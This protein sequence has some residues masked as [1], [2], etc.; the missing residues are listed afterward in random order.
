MVPG[1]GEAGDPLAL[2]IFEQQAM[3]L[4]RL[5]SIAAMFTDPGTYFVGGRRASRP[6]P[7]SAEWFLG[8]IREHTTLRAEQAKLVDFVLVPDLDRAGRAGRRA[9]R[10]LGH[11]RP[12][13][14]LLGGR[15]ASYRPAPGTIPEA[16]ASTGSATSTAG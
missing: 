4:G 8:R 13:I 14:E 5:F 12:R 16:P 7:P 6:I 15:P 9:R 11:R 10:T 1:C 2:K 3:A